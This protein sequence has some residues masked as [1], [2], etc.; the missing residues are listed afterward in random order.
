MLI[1]CPPPMR[2]KQQGKCNFGKNTPGTSAEIPLIG[3]LSKNLGVKTGD[4]LYKDSYPMYLPKRV[5]WQGMMF[6]FPMG[7]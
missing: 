3:K 6:G 5:D 7:S 1:L 2:N 4:P